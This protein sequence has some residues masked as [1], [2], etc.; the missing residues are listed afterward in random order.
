MSLPEWLVLAILSEQPMHGFALAQ[1]FQDGR[2]SL[3]VL[4]WVASGAAFAWC[5]CAS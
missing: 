2:A 4:L 3:T 1:L 5:T